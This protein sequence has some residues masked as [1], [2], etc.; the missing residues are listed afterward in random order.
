MFGI[1]VF[2]CIYLCVPGPLQPQ[3]HVEWTPE[4]RQVLAPWPRAL[5]LKEQQIRHL[6]ARAAQAAG[7]R[8]PTAH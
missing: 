1:L 2:E 5:S 7:R 8:G 3:V 4:R 6:S